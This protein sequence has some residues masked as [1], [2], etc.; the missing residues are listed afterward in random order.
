MVSFMDNYE[1]P[2]ITEG[3]SEAV[4][5]YTFEIKESVFDTS[6][7]IEHQTHIRSIVGDKETTRNLFKEGPSSI[8]PPKKVIPPS[9]NPFSLKAEKKTLKR[10]Q[11]N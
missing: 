3:R 9:F 7:E 1:L 6:S 11:I 8:L 2:N 5:D 4:I 10:I